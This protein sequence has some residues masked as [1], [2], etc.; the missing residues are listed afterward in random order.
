MG[1]ADLVDTA[2]VELVL[3]GF[4][5]RNALTNGPRNKVDDCPNFDPTESNNE[6]LGHN[7]LLLMDAFIAL[8]AIIIKFKK[9]RCF[10]FFRFC[11]FFELNKLDQGNF[12]REGKEANRTTYNASSY[13]ST[14][15]THPPLARPSTGLLLLATWDLLLL[16]TYRTRLKAC[17]L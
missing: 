17:C 8:A 5:V 2:T 13:Y 1:T 12:T 9:I 6:E 11:C 10:F 3:K 4:K 7:I 14:T 15:D 16:A